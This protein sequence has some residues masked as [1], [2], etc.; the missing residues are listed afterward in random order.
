[1]AGTNVTLTVLAAPGFAFD[2]WSG[3]VSGFDI[4]VVVIMDGD[5]ALTAHFKG[6]APL[7]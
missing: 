4:E 1:M 2:H 3:D 7:P 6:K 5:R